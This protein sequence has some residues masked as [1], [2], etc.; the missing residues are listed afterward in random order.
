M[1]TQATEKPTAPRSIGKVATLPLDALIPSASNRE[2]R[3]DEDLRGLAT[4]IKNVGLIYPLVVRP[5]TE[6]E[7]A[8]RISIGERRWR[9]MKLLK[10]E[11]APCIV[12]SSKE[13]ET[14]AEILR[15][16]ENHQRKNL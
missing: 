16:V 9:A 4:S 13:D 7:G 10:L 1:T 6:Q 14:T 11:A 15:V 8:Y 5:D 12:L 2:A 3:K